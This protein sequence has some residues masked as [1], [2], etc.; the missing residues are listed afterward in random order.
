M[1]KEL[2]DATQKWLFETN[3]HKWSNN[4]NTAG[5]NYGSFIAGAKWMGERSYS[6]EEVLKLL[7][8]ITGVDPTWV[9]EWFEENKKK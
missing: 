1:D 5:D 3:G 4:D 7:N 8:D 9:K 2:D 6:E